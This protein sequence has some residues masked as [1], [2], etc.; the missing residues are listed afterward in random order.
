M[1]SLNPKDGRTE[2]KLLCIIDRISKRLEIL[3]WKGAKFSIH[4]HNKPAINCGISWIWAFAW[5]I[6]SPV[7]FYEMCYQRTS[8]ARNYVLIIYR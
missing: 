5:K 2:I 4:F 6:L 8:S 1:K 7:I 3:D